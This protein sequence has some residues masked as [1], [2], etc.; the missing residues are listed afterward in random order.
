MQTVGLSW[1]VGHMMACVQNIHLDVTEYQRQG[2]CGLHVVTCNLRTYGCLSVQHT[3]NI[4]EYTNI[5][6]IVQMNNTV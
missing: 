6:V 5:K 4:M 1:K 3:V 2:W